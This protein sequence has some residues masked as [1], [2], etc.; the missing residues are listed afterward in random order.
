MNGLDFGL[1]EVG[2]ELLRDEMG[3]LLLHLQQLVQFVVLPDTKDTVPHSILI[4]QRLDDGRFDVVPVVD[5]ID[6]HLIGLLRGC[7]SL[8]LGDQL[9]DLH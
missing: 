8:N 5:L 2:Q 9:D 7:T 4:L 6:D 3:L 1:L